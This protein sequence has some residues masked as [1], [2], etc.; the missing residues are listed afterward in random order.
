M[1]WGKSAVSP[2][3]MQFMA[4]TDRIA[5]NG[6]VA[7]D[8][9][10]SS[11][12][13]QM[14]KKKGIITTAECRK[15]LAALAEIRKLAISGKFK[16]TCKQEDCHTAIEEFLIKKTGNAGKKI[17][18]GRS[19]NDQVAVALRLYYL[20]NLKVT[21]RKIAQLSMQLKK[22]IKKYICPAIHIQGRQCPPQLEYGQAV[23][24]IH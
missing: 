20:E 12:H 3:L 4:G 15:L 11:A 5:D 16:I 18:F 9:I 6:L 23:S 24:S 13:A 22:F 8:C 19:R 10:A 14:L 21:K 2:A 1:L 7:Y 17:H